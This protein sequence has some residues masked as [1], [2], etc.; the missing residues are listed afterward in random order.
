MEND[1]GINSAD[2][3]VELF[4]IADITGDGL[5]RPVDLQTIEQIRQSLRGK[6][7][8]DNLSS[9]R[10]Q[11]E[12]E[13]TSLEPRMTGDQNSFSV[14]EFFPHLPDFPGRVPIGPRGLELPF[15]PKRVHALPETVVLVGHRLVLA[16][17][18]FEDVQLQNAV[19]A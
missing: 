16:G 10:P 14:P 15:I 13:P 19:I 2:S 4:Q 11:P 9:Q 3:G 18:T 12:C 1:L 5:D 8:P 7:I 17:E 6:G